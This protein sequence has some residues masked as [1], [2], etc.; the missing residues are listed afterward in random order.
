MQS[1]LI[2]PNRREDY[3][4][5]KQKKMKATVIGSGAMGSGIAQVMAAAGSEVMLFDLN[6]EMVNRAL[7]QIR[8][9]AKRLV[10]KGKMH[11]AD[12]DS[13]VGRI[14]AISNLRVCA[15]SELVIEA[16][17][18][19]LSIKQALFT[20]IEGIVSEDTILA[21]NTS[22]LSV[23]SISAALKNKQRFL[24]IHFFNPAPL[25][26]LVE[27]IPGYITSEAVLTKVVHLVKDWGKVGVV[28]NDTPGFIVNRLARPFY[29]EAL[30]IAEEGIAN[31]ETIDHAM[32]SLG[33]F[34]MGPF[35]LMDFIGH[36]V[37][38]RVTE[39]VWQQ[40][41]YDAR[42]RPS[43]IQ[44]RLFESGLYGK[45]SGRGYYLYEN[46]NRLA[47]EVNPDLN[48]QSGIFERVMVMLF[49]EALEALYLGIAAAEDLDKAMMKGVNYPQGLISWAQTWGHAKV[50]SKLE[51]LHFEY[52]DDRYRPSVMLRNMV[53]GA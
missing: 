49:N 11:E 51:E 18:E 26:P 41:F 39:T 9:N 15:G 5:A 53:R 8:Q 32:K 44:K 12:A 29:G 3:L 25:M 16:I 50:L 47:Q 13:M 30:R 17:I 37:N 40:M 27:I 23:A 45:K 38:Y 42:Y 24:G 6:A 1:Y 2:L 19:D 31:F 14:K 48:L 52:G 36:D 22:S 33:G 21:T 4:W 34:R 10:E 35:E 7:A 20:E 28:A 43:L 46:D